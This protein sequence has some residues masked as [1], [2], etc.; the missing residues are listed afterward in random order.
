MDPSKEILGSKKSFFPSSSFGESLLPLL[1][2]A[3]VVMAM[4]NKINVFNLNK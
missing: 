2:Q 4:I 3:V 1:K